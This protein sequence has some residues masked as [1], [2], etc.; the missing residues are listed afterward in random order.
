MATVTSTVTVNAAFLQEIKED[1]VELTELLERTTAMTQL[2]RW[3]H[4]EANRFYDHLAD[5][6][7]RL[8]THFALEEAYGYFEDAISVAPRLAEEAESLRSQ[9]E[10][11]FSELCDI[12]EL[13]ER[14]RY[15]ETRLAKF[16]EVLQ[17]FARF[18]ER[19]KTH[20]EAEADLILAAFNDDIG[21][22]D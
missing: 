2:R 7:D 10:A 22:G 11:M 9:H 19:L 3:T 8:A 13:A 17:R 12:V 1:N 6:R 15:H 4:A 20:E 21:V 16:H 14:V 5:L 18:H